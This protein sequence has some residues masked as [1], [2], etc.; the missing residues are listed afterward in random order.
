[1]DTKEKVKSNEVLGCIAV[2][3]VIATAFVLRIIF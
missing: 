3:I 1:M 2:G